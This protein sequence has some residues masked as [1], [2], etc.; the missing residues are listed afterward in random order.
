MANDPA[1]YSIHRLNGAF[2]EAAHYYV[3]SHDSAINFAKTHEDADV[4][5]FLIVEKERLKTV[6]IRGGKDV[7]I[8]KVMRVTQPIVT[9]KI[10][11]EYGIYIIINSDGNLQGIHNTG[12]LVWEQA[13]NNVNGAFKCI[14]IQGNLIYA[15]TEKG[16]YRVFNIFRCCDCFQ[17]A[18]RHFHQIDRL[19]I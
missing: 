8:T 6:E 1:G 4:T 3:P 9:I 7:K 15:G 5:Q 18:E 17:F 19:L 13:K 12:G 2:E 14:T 16:K 11:L 10:A